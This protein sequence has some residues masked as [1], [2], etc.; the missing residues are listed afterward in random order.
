MSRIGEHKILCS[1]MYGAVYAHR[2]KVMPVSTFVHSREIR[3]CKCDSLI[4]SRCN[5]LTA[6]H[7]GSVAN[8]PFEVMISKK[9]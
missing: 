6:T 2:L 3:L 1:P 8:T 5:Y 9:T 7:T 4:N